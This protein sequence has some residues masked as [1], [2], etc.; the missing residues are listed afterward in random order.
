MAKK[1]PQTYQLNAYIYI[2]ITIY[3]P[4]SSYIFLCSIHYIHG[5]LLVFLLK[6]TS[7]FYNVVIYGELRSG[8]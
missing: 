2:C 8:L 1:T 6:T 4:H 3:L 5:V 7:F